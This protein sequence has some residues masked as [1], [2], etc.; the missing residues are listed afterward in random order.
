MALEGSKHSN[1]ALGLAVAGYLLLASGSVITKLPWADEGIFAGPAF[2]LITN[3]YMGTSVL[4]T[5][6]TA[7]KGLERHTYLILPMHI[8]AQ[9]G[10][11]EIFGF[12]LFSMRAMSVVWGLVAL[13]SWYVILRML[14]GKRTVAT[15]AVI[16]IALD[17]VF[18]ST[19]ASGRM[20]MMNAALGAAGL[21]VYL[22]WRERHFSWAIFM[23]HALVMAGGLTHPNGILYLAGLLFLML[24]FDRQSIGW[25]Q[26]GLAAIPYA[27]GGASWGLY[28]LEDPANFMTQFFGNVSDGSRMRYSSAPWLGIEAE[29]VGRYLG[30]FGMAPETAGPS[31]L[32][33]VIPI[34][35]MI[36]VA[37]FL[38]MAELRE[39]RGYR[40][41][42][43]LA[44]MSF[45]IL[46]VLDGQKLPYYLIH[47]VPFFDAM[48]A[49]WVVHRS[50]RSARPVW[51]VSL[52][53]GAFMISQVSISA[54]RIA[55]NPYQTRYLPV[56]AFL[57]QRSTPTSLI[58]GSAALA[59]GLGFDGHVLDDPRL[60]YH[61]GK[62][63][64]FVVVG[65]VDYAQYFENYKDKEP[66]V[67]EYVVKRLASDYQM[68]YDHAGRQIY[69]RR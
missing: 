30:Y 28:I 12:G 36:G 39:Q 11:D 40:A 32:K 52:I 8:L 59:F 5:A 41:L 33:I 34:I 10:W 42:A 16:F 56:I 31:R 14:S 18:V 54:Y 45:L 15:A 38:G 64:D 37:G 62:T 27:A 53:V 7:W 69:E 50:A 3:G 63:A 17:C 24:Y 19:S 68:V 2:N 46:A 23:A 44:V 49:A 61:S 57:N 26:I 65:D 66:A 13:L 55:Q 43:A 51:A 58:M 25:R 47:T 9:A 22:R 1:I 20:D 35:Q 60:G 67:Y 48:L 29:F 4:E 21:A 6:G